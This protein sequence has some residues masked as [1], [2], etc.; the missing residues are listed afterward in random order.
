MTALWPATR[1]CCCLRSIAAQHY[2][3]LAN[4]TDSYCLSDYDFG[5]AL[6]GS[7]NSQ[8]FNRHADW[9]PCISDARYLFNASFVATSYW[10]SNNKFMNQLLKNWELAPLFQARTGQPLTIT[11]GTD[12]S[13]TD[14]NNDRPNQVLSDWHATTGCATK[15]SASHGLIRRL[16]WR[17]QLV[18]TATSGAMQCADPACSNLMF[19]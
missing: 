16:S 3:F 9:G 6:A 14:L 7:T 17:I 18:P 11:T 13:R 4:F 19:R 10:E 2:T 8:I 5:A 12:N 1:A 15:R